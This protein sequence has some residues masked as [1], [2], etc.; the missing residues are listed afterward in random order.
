M[1]QMLCTHEALNV[2][3]VVHTLDNV[4][5][6]VC[7]YKIPSVHRGMHMGGIRLT[8]SPDLHS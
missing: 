6:V 8:L 4:T 1:S 7:T 2:H 5:E 3:R